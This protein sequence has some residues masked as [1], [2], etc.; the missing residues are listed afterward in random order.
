MAA[1]LGNYYF[2]IFGG[3]LL[4]IAIFVLLY[5]KYFGDDDV[6]EIN[7]LGVILRISI[8]QA[9]FYGQYILITFSVDLLANETFWISQV[10]QSPEFSFY[11]TRGLAT[12]FSLIVAFLSLTL[13]LAATVQHSL[14]MT[15]YMCTAFLLHFIV[16]SS[17]DRAF[18]ANGAWWAA[19]AIGI[20]LGIFSSE[21]VTHKLE[22]MSYESS[23]GGSAKKTPKSPEPMRSN[24]HDTRTDAD[25][26][27]T[28]AVRRPAHTQSSTSIQI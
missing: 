14:S 26:H 19:C 13:P 11:T 24:A 28:Q 6:L 15:D 2:L 20:V 9:F 12:F 1:D 23:L 22:M 5:E 18:P 3:C 25:A 27:A 10:F 7:P 17:V 16:V 8:I 4:L 21:F